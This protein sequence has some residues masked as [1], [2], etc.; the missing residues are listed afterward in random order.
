MEVHKELGHGFLEA[1]YQ[2]ALGR[3]FNYQE[4]PFRSQQARKIS[5]KGKTLEKTYIADFICYDE[6]TLSLQ[7][8][9]M[10]YLQDVQ[11]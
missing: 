5:Y 3:E 4:V 7:K 9:R 6:G 8:P 1:V 2:E 11:G 10:L